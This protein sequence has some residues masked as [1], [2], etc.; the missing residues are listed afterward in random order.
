MTD[1]VI[2]EVAF[3]NLDN[4][5]T[6]TAFTARILPT[7]FGKAVTGRLDWDRAAREVMSELDYVWPF[8]PERWLLQVDY[9]AEK[10]YLDESDDWLHPDEKARRARVEAGTEADA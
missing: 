6:M 8:T 5:R 1:A 10:M 4:V 3:L 7:R 2:L 9:M